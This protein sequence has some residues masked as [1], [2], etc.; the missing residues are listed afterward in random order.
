MANH[1]STAVFG[2]LRTAGYDGWLV[3]EAE[4]DPAIADPV[5]YATLGYRTL[6]QLAL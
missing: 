6:S 3:I 4:Q 2:P 5:T 1:R